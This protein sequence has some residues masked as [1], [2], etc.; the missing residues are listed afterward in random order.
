MASRVP[1]P[2]H[3]DS[4]F[5]EVTLGRLFCIRPY[6]ARPL[7]LTIWQPRQ[8][9]HYRAASLTMRQSCGWVSTSS[10]ARSQMLL[11]GRWFLKG[12]VRLALK[13]VDRGFDFPFI[14]PPHLSHKTNSLFL[15]TRP[16][17]DLNHSLDR[18]STTKN[19]LRTWSARYPFA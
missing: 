1:G 19:A 10:V 4:A 9:R 5:S 3:L 17:F 13:F 11:P 16:S 18:Y 6:D 12:Q 2:I 14:P 7:Y 8:S 15:S